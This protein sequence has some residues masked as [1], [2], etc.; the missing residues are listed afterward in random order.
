MKNK[1]LLTFDWP[2]FLPPVVADSVHAAGLDPFDNSDAFFTCAE[3]ID[4]ETLSSKQLDMLTDSED[5]ARFLQ[6]MACNPR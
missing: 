6:E 5:G 2:S 4:G 1:N 3:F